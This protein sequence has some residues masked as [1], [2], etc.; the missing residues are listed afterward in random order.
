[1]ISDPFDYKIA[2]PDGRSWQERIN[3][4]PN[5]IT[6]DVE[7]RY[8]SDSTGSFTATVLDMNGVPV[9]TQGLFINSCILNLRALNPGMYIIRIYNVS[10]KEY[11]N[12]I[13][14]KK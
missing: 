3:I 10:R 12:K 2:I 4:G 14:M 1:M 5:P 6:G 11:M 8:N 9:K 7:I 13:I